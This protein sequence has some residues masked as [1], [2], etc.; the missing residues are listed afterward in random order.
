M[1]LNE[2]VSFRGC[3]F[4]IIGIDAENKTVLLDATRKS[5]RGF[6]KVAEMSKVS[7]HKPNPKKFKV[8]P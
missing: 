2:R 4:L 8:I 5:L 1:K 3:D 7:T 6:P